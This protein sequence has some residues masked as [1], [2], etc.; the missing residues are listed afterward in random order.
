MADRPQGLNA[1]WRPRSLACSPSRPACTVWRS[2]APFPSLSLSFSV[3]LSLSAM[4]SRAEHHRSFFFSVPPHSPPAAAT[5]SASSPP[6]HAR[7]AVSQGYRC[8]RQRCHQQGRRGH[9]WRTWPGGY[10]PLLAGPRP[11]A[12]EARRRQ[13]PARVP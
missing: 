13:A 6:P 8:S 2:R 5:I 11:G 3:S 9:C 12:S 7:S 10:G 4:E 1:A